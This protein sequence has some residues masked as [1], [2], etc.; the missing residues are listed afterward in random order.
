VLYVP[1]TIAPVLTNMRY[2][3]TVQPIIFIFIAVAL[4]ELA[5]RSG[6]LT[7]RPAARGR[8]GTRTAPAP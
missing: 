3:V 7:T 8:A 4:T 1:L 6:L 2:S 5:W